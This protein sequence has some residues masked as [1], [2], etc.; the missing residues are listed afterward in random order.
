MKIQYNVKLQLEME[1]H[2]NNLRYNYSALSAD[3]K[4]KFHEP[5]KTFDRRT[6]GLYFER[7]S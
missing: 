7:T 2:S 3:E 5:E 1:F 6:K 4:E